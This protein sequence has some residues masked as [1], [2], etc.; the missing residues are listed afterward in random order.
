MEEKEEPPQYSQQNN[1]SSFAEGATTTEN[2]QKRPSAHPDLLDPRDNVFRVLQV[3]HVEDSTVQVFDNALRHD[4]THFRKL[5][6][7]KPQVL[8]I[9][10][11]GGNVASGLIRSKLRVVRGHHLVHTV[12]HVWGPSK[13]GVWQS[14][15]RLRY[16]EAAHNPCPHID[17]SS[18]AALFY[19]REYGFIK[20]NLKK[21]LYGDFRPLPIRESHPGDARGY[22]CLYCSTTVGAVTFTAGN[23]QTYRMFNVEL[24]TWHDLGLLESPLESQWLRLAAVKSLALTCPR[25]DYRTMPFV[26]QAFEG[27]V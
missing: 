3:D 8:E 12:L 17:Y 18:A 9:Q 7:D 11:G 1:S 20:F 24:H 6:K 15:K 13:Y 2:E 22:S 14:L 21:I 19:P 10:L 26:S 27:S 4:F 23:S 25:P 5:Y 16:A